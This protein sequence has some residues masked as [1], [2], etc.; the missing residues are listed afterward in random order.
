MEQQGYQQNRNQK[1]NFRQRG[2]ESPQPEWRTELLSPC[3]WGPTPS[4]MCTNSPTAGREHRHTRW[5]RKAG[6]GCNHSKHC[7]MPGYQLPDCTSSSLQYV[8]SRSNLEKCF[9]VLWM[10]ALDAWTHPRSIT[11][12]SLGVRSTNLVFG[13]SGCSGI[14]APFSILFFF[15]P[16][17][18]FLL[19]IVHVRESA[20]DIRVCLRG[21][22]QTMFTFLNLFLIRHSLSY[23]N[24]PT[25]A[26]TM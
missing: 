8:H 9:W 11:R 13:P 20:V 14:S 22:L 19:R 16:L 17:P 18:L 3:L 25:Q 2:T 4:H 15:P 7:R 26:C 1:P 10:V 6:Y 21:Y 24:T 5:A 23:T 12:F